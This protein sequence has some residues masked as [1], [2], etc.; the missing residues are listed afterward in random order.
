M[1]PAMDSATFEFAG[2][3]R[4]RIRGPGPAVAH[5]RFEYGPCMVP[6]PVPE[7]DPVDAVVTIG[8]PADATTGGTEGG[9][10]T[11]GWRVAVDGATA[12]PMTHPL[13]LWIA[14]RGRPQSFVRS[15]VQG[16]FVEPLVSLVAP[17]RGLALVPAAAIALDDELV[18]ILG[19]SRAGKST[20]AARAMANGRTVLGDDQ[21]FLD[22]TGTCWPFPRRLRFY[23]DLAETAPAA[24]A[25]LR[26]PSRRALALRRWAGRLSRGWVRPSL[27]VDRTEL[28]GDWTPTG[29]PVGRI[30]IVERS[31][32]A[33]SIQ[34]S[35]ALPAAAVATAASLLEEQRTRLAGA[36]RPAWTNRF[37]EARALEASILS[38]GFASIAVERIVV[39]DRWAAAASI[40]GLARE[41]G[42]EDSVP[43][44]PASHR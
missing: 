20:L 31:S 39:P 5:F 32:S 24:Y 18:L 19:R 26:P 10:K 4:L 41:L 1:A 15:L 22:R 27:A 3:V 6:G 36:S 14:I 37:A 2:R 16:Y 29:L 11:V 34:A 23:P 7:D 12:H 9:H 38:D 42:L 13:A 8:G 44:R 17:G 43:H 21:V 40:S 25:R 28:G 33:G 35:S 30:V